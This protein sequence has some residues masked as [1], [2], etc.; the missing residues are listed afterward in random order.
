MYK[1]LNVSFTESRCSVAFK[2]SSC[3]LETTE[4][5]SEPF[6][7]D[8]AL[9]GTT[10]FDLNKGCFLLEDVTEKMLHKV[11]ERWLL[12]STDKAYHS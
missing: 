9:W 12:W 3:S 11:K 1:P 8:L 5:C 7:K 2:V 10:A 4:G 6:Y